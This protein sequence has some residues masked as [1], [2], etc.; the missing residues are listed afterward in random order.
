MICDHEY[1]AGVVSLAVAR[2]LTMSSSFGMLRARSAVIAAG[3]GA[4]TRGHHER[5]RAVATRARPAAGSRRFSH[6]S[7]ATHPRLDGHANDVYD[8][9]QC[10]REFSWNV[11]YF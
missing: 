11:V 1:P 9:F 2:K 5:V 3:P 6:G 10:N 4:T 7:S 8:V